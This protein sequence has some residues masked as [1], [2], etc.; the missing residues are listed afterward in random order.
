MNTKISTHVCI[1]WDFIRNLWWW[2]LLR[3]GGGVVKV[4]EQVL[5]NQPLRLLSSG[6]FGILQQLPFRSRKV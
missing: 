4:T 5:S 2:G 1:C 6:T 3:G